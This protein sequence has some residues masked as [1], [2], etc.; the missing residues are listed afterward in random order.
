MGSPLTKAVIELDGWV[1]GVTIKYSMVNSG[2]NPLFTSYILRFTP[3]D[4]V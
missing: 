2:G 1:M 4:Y 3:E